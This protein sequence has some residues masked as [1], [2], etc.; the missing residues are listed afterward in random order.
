MIMVIK[1]NDDIFLKMKKLLV[2]FPVFLLFLL[3]LGMLV[4]P[5][6]AIDLEAYY[7]DN[8]YAYD[9]DNA[10]DVWI[11]QENKLLRK[12]DDRYLLLTLAVKNNGGLKAEDLDIKCNLSKNKV[13]DLLQ[14]RKRV[15]DVDQGSS[16]SVTLYLP[17][18]MEREILLC[19]LLQNDHKIPGSDT[20]VFLKLDEKL[21]YWKKR[22]QLKIDEIKRMIR[23]KSVYKNRL[24]SFREYADGD[25]L[26]MKLRD[27][28]AR[29]YTEEEMSE[30]RIPDGRIGIEI[31]RFKD[32]TV[33]ITQVLDGSPA[34]K[35][36]LRVGDVIQSVDGH[37]ALRYEDIFELRRRIWG[38][39]GERVKIVIRRDKLSSTSTVL[40]KKMEAQAL[41]FSEDDGF[42]LIKIPIFN[43]NNTLALEEYLDELK[44]ND[45]RGIIIDLR[46]NSGGVLAEVINSLDFFTEEEKALVWLKGSMGISLK[47]ARD[48]AMVTDIPIIILVNNQTR[49]GAEMFAGVMQQYKLAK[50]M[51]E[52]TSGDNA[53]LEYVTLDDGSYL[54][55][56]SGVWAA[57]ELNID[58]RARALRPNYIYVDD[59]ETFKIDEAVEKAKNILLSFRKS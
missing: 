25:D 42:Y 48:E 38:E 55:L 23:G 54:R 40:R 49:S 32:G 19:V 57:A 4:L 33:R 59:H 9:L 2:Y 3:F 41:D 12:V 1:Y 13:G 15:S 30:L 28:N 24:R 27:E 34:Y 37:A 14:L 29:I 50:I 21:D 43:F 47:L 8:L 44:R 45:A 20:D 31:A 51:G 6:V 53:V 46:N 39:A 16:Q 11:D 5:A 22:A 26:L 7:L 52:R 17:L 58:F 35:D 10:N 36:G 18:E 56:T